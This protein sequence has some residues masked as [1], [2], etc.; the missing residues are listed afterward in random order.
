MKLTVLSGL[1][2]YAAAV[3]GGRPIR[4][5]IDPGAVFPLHAGAAGKVLMCSLSRQSIRWYY[6][7]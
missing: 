5:S 4:V 3:E 1:R 6:V 7:L 2:S